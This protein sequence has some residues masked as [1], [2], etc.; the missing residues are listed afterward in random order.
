VTPADGARVV[1]VDDVPVDLVLRSQEHLEELLREMQIITIG[2]QTATTA[3]NPTGRVGRLVGEALERLEA[4]RALTHEQ[5]RAVADAGGAL[6]S[7]ELSLPEGA[8]EDIRRLTELL[9]E[10]DR[11]CEEGALITLAS[12]PEVR[13]FRRDMAERLIRQLER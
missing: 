9:E 11:L 4:A 12:P 5:A 7:L 8:A 6:V 13:S 10:A 2:M 3:D 1:R